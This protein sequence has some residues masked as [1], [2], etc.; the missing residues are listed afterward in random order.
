[1]ANE[2]GFEALEASL[3]ASLAI[4][5]VVEICKVS[6]EEVRSATLFEQA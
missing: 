3:A 5:K 2:R 1:M 4:T 6:K